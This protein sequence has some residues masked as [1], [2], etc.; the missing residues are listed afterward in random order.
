[1]VFTPV[2]AEI[3]LVVANKEKETPG[4]FGDR[5]AYAQV[6]I[7]P[8]TPAASSLT[9]SLHRHSVFSMLGGLSALWSDQYVNPL[10]LYHFRLA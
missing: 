1:M 10:L 8:V 7:Y 6:D 5:G 3:S 9:N 2:M 4:L